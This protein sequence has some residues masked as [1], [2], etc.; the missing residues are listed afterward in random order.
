MIA[1]AVFFVLLNPLCLCRGR[2]ILP[3]VHNRIHLLLFL[4]LLRLR[5]WFAV[6]LDQVFL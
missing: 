4:F 5:D 6:N 2:F 3:L 1:F